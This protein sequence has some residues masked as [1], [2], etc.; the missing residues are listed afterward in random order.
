MVGV[1]YFVE[2]INEFEKKYGL[3][4]YFAGGVLFGFCFV[5]AGN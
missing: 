3:F 1:C 2:I 5:F 4:V